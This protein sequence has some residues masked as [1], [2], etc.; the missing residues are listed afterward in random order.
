MESNGEVGSDNGDNS[1]INVNKTT[2]V[3]LDTYTTNSIDSLF[4]NTNSPHNNNASVTSDV[5]T[6]IAGV[7][8]AI[9][10]LLGVSIAL[11]AFVLALRI[12][13]RYNVINAKFSESAKRCNQYCKSI[14]P[15]A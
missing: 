15:V 10:V 7:V 6:L 13:A 12:K 5:T 9:I 14:Y 1:M 4:V 3:T 11:V 8:I 2:S